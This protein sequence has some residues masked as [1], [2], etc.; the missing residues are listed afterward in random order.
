MLLKLLAV[1]DAQ[2]DFI[3]VG[4]SAQLQPSASEAEVTL[5]KEHKDELLVLP[6][7]GPSKTKVVCTYTHKGLPPQRIRRMKQNVNVFS[8]AQSARSGRL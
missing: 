1:E 8:T 2:R 7:Y 4:D 6:S 3:S 5:E